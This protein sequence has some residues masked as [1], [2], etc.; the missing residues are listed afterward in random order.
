MPKDAYAQ[1]KGFRLHYLDW[2]VNGKQPMLLLHGFMAHAHTWDDFA[3]DFR[4]RYHV[5]ALDQRGHGDSEWSKDEAYSLDDHFSDIAYLIEFLKLKDLVLMGHSM[6]GRNALFYAACHPENVEKLIVI[7]SRPADSLQSSERLRY[8]L[9]HL[10]LQAGSLDEI[11]EA[12]QR[13]Y[14]LLSTKICHALASHG[15]KED[16]ST[17]QFVPKY[18]MRMGFHLDRMGCITEDLWPFMKNVIC[19]TLIVRGEESPFLSRDD[20]QKMSVT[21]PQATW[22][23]IPR[24][25]HMPVQENPDAFEGVISEFLKEY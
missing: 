14:P 16:G 21:I 2:G 7:D 13:L 24:A 12:I 6:G 5:I 17:G 9:L 18:D 4:D 23:E 11:A 1:I 10:P 19:P 25:T 20:A 15:Y 8:D 22:V 3:S